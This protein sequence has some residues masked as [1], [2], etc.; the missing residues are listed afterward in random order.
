MATIW[1]DLETLEIL[2]KGQPITEIDDDD[3]DGDSALHQAALQEHP[4][5][6]AF[7]ADLGANVDMPNKKGLT[8]IHDAALLGS[9]DCVEILLAKGAE[10]NLLDKRDR[11]VLFYACLGTSSETANLVLDTLLEKKTPLAEI[12]AKTKQDR[13]PLRQA[14]GR[15]FDTVVAKLIKA[16]Q[17]EGHLDSLAINQSDKRKGKTPLHRA[18]WFGQTEVV[19][20]LLGAGADAKIKD[21]NNKTALV[22]AY[23]QW[24]LTSQQKAF[25][26]VISLLIESDTEAAKNDPELVA[27]CAVNGSI[28]LLKQLVAIGADLNRQDQ[29][30]WTPLE[31]LREF[32]EKEAGELLKQQ[33][34]WAGMLPSRWADDKQTSVS[35]EGLVVNH[36]GGD[37]VCISANKP[38]PARFERFYFEITLKELKE[39]RDGR[40][41]WAEV[42]LVS[43]RKVHWNSPSPLTYLCLRVSAL[44]AVK[45]LNSLG[46]PHALMHPLPDLGHIMAIME[47]FIKVSTSYESWSKGKY[48]DSIRKRQ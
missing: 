40:P 10:S 2:C 21:K 14:A 27:I 33:G 39:E 17:A 11:N 28:R 42:A 1:G 9:K 5:I 19:R 15:G 26:D 38:L 48:A 16:A 12:N 36:S 24:V 47:L 35:E 22:L 6:I 20:L 37:R 46:G 8:A 29:Y 23:E 25:E 32:Q 4:K 7:L 18:A 44:S 13:T 43:Y 41:E 30:G 31:L 45:L 3:N 34:A